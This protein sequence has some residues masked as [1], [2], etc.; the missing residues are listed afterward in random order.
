MSSMLGPAPILDFDGTIAVLSVDWAHLR[1]RLGVTRI[2]DLWVRGD[3]GAWELVREAEVR[4]AAQAEPVLPVFRALEETVSFS[5]LTSNAEQAVEEF[6]RRFTALRAKVAAVVGREALGGP[7]WDPKR[8]R[9]G[10]ER[11]ARATMVSRGQGALVYVGNADYE[12]ELAAEIGA[13]AI[14]VRQLLRSGERL[15]PD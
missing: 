4:A 9:A 10:F 8:F 11:C 13:I 2:D 5:I 6:F 7:K 1:Q 15:G 14:D 3:V 12:L